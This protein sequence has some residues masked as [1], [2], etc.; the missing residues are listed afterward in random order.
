MEHRNLQE[1]DIVLIQDSNAIRGHWKM[2][3]V[4]KAHQ[5]NDGK[6]RKVD[7]QYKINDTWMTID[8]PV[9]KLVLL[10]PACDDKVLASDT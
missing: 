9:Q 4:I 2:G 7:V 6:V 5:S 1:N 10:L 3:K 8:R